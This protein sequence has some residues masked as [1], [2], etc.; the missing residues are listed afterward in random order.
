[1]QTIQLIGVDDIE[2][3]GDFHY[4]VDVQSSSADSD[5]N[6]KSQEL[7]AINKDA[8]TIEWVLPENHHPY[9]EWAGPSPILLGVEPVGEEPI[10]IDAIMFKRWNPRIRCI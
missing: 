2:G 1:M 5:Y 6:A 3:D 9:Y 4:T 7:F 10:P 8:P